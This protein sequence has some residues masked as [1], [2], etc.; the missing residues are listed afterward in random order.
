MITFE[1]FKSFIE[2][3]ESISEK[4]LGEVIVCTIKS[5]QRSID[6]DVRNK[7]VIHKGVVALSLS[8]EEHDEVIVDIKARK[9]TITSEQSR[10]AEDLS[11]IVKRI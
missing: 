11:E 9:L 4:Y 7:N 2:K 10:A 3:A 6:Y 1:Q 8:Q 5:V